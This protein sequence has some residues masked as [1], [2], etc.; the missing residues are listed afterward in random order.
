MTAM[1]DAADVDLQQHD[2]KAYSADCRLFTQISKKKHIRV[3]LLASG[4]SMWEAGTQ[5]TAGNSLQEPARRYDGTQAGKRGIQAG[6]QCIQA[7]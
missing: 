4:L 2:R 3:N 5:A 1:A 6:R 7:G